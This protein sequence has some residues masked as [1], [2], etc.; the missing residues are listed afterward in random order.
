MSTILDREITEAAFQAQVLHY[1]A[2]RNWRTAHFRTSLDARGNYQTAVAGDGAGWPDLFCV[3]GDRAVAIELK[4]EKGRVRPN[5]KEWLDALQAAGVEAHVFR[6]RD[7]D[8][9]QEVLR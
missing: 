6:P 7:W 9:L 8:Q 1:A 4:A 2:L 3:R 5:Q